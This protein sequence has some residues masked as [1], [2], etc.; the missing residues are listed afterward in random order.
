MEKIFNNTFKSFLAFWSALVTITAI[1]SVL[2][3]VLYSV[4]ETTT[5]LILGL[6]LILIFGV[7][8]AI[9]FYRERQDRNKIIKLEE[10]KSRSEETQRQKI[11]RERKEKF[12]NT[13]NI[14]CY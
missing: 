2:I 12:L 14:Y 11:I 9:I 1:S 7:G 13:D 8:I 6:L 4:S 3:D 10:E 5:R